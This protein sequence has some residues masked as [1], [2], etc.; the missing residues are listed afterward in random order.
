MEHFQENDALLR[1]EI[2]NTIFSFGTNKKIFNSILLVSKLEKWQ[3]LISTMHDISRF[4]LRD[5]ETS[6]YA[7]LA[8]QAVMETLSDVAGSRWKIADPTGEQALAVAGAIRKNLRIL[9]RSGRISKES[10]GGEL[11][12][13]K[14][15]LADAILRPEL[16]QQI[17]STS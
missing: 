10:A 13:I 4:Q 1:R 11:A 9:Y 8:E 12:R 6:E 16:L 14:G 17:I 5:E 7:A 3:Q 15:C 2:A